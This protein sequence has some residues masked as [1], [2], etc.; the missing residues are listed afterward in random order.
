VNV[1]NWWIHYW[2]CPHLCNEYVSDQVSLSVSKAQIS[3]QSR[4]TVVHESQTD[5]FSA[6]ISTVHSSCPIVSPHLWTGSSKD[7]VIKVVKWLCRMIHV[8]STADCRRQLLLS[9]T[10]VIV[11]NGSAD[12]WLVNKASLHS[13]RCWTESH[14]NW[15]STCEMWSR[16]LAPVMRYAVALWIYCSYW[17]RPSDTS[18]SNQLWWSRQHEMMLMLVFCFCC[19]WNEQ[20]DAMAAVKV[21]NIW[22]G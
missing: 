13:T 21:G 5:V 4:C 10:K 17:N 6:A 9:V 3:I 22:R 1:T 20:L 12:K 2:T 16:H 15:Y 14:C 19:Q 18:Y 11:C 7:L 8:L